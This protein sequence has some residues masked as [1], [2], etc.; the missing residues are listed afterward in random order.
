MDVRKGQ[1]GSIMV[2]ILVLLFVLLILASQALPAAFRFYRQAAVE[3]EAEKLL[4][5]IRYCQNMS[6]VTAE[7]AWNYG[8]ADAGDHAVF[9]RMRP[10][11]NYIYAGEGDV[12]GRHDYLPGIRACK[13]KMDGRLDKSEQKI[14]FQ[15]NGRPLG[16]ITVLIYFEG[17]EREGRE[18][19][20]S[21]GGRIRMERGKF[22]R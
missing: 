16:L 11:Y 18:I 3:Y 12:L 8:A 10:A 17:Y 20:V 14:I 22:G 21:N 7:L 5:D 1:Q 13:K 4:A 2:E 6:R 9:L 15:A 19:M